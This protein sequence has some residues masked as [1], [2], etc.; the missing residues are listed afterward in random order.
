MTSLEVKIYRG[1]R[2]ERKRERERDDTQRTYQ[3]N[4]ISERVALQ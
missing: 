2:E 4:T 3:H 1:M